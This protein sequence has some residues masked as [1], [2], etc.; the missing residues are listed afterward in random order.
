MVGTD[1]C[2]CVRCGC[3]GGRIE[4]TEGPFVLRIE[5]ASDRGSGFRVPSLRGGSEDPNPKCCASKD[6][7]SSIGVKML[8]ELE[9]IFLI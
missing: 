1:D 2:D 5:P 8:L 3:A 7:L 4:P 9:D 6:L